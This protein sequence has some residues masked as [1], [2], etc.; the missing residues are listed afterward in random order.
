[1]TPVL[2]SEFTADQTTVC[3]G[4]TVNFINESISYNTSEWSFEGGTP[5]T[6][7]EE[8]PS[9]VYST[10]GVYD[11]ELT[12]TDISGASD[13]ELKLDYITVVDLPA[14]AGVPDG[15][16]ETCA[17]LYYTYSVD[18][19]LYAQEYEWELSP[20]GAGTLDAN[21]NE[22]IIEFA[23]DW[24][25]DFT[26]KVRAT[27]VCGNGE[28]SDNFEGTVSESPEDFNLMGGGTYCLDGEGVEITL[29]GSQSGIGYELYLGEEPTGII[30]D[31]TG[32]EISFGLV[33]DEGYYIAIGSNENCSVTMS[34]QVQVEIVYPP[35][36]P[37]TPTGPTLVCNDTVSNYES[38][39]TV[40]AE[41]YQ[42]ILEPENAGAINAD[43]LE[44]VV[45][46]NT[47]FI[48]SAFIS[49]YGINECGDGDPSAEIEVSVG[50]ANPEIEGENLVCD[51]HSEDYEVA[52]N[53]GSSYN[54]TVTGGT[55]STGQGTYTITVLWGEA[56]VGLISVEEQSGDGCSGTSD[57]FE[58]T[59]DDCTGIDEASD[60]N[61]LMLFPNPTSNELNVSFNTS[62]DHITIVVYNQL[63]Q[64]M[65]A[66]E[67]NTSNETKSLKLNV[68][69]FTK[70]M[71][72]IEIKSKGELLYHKQFIKR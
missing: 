50:G 5:S 12:V 13:S 21:D 37:L 59:I 32:S 33:T 11:V 25:G 42:W 48:G 14:Q 26:L 57:E 7:T 61:A 47:D 46:W 20:T 28:W 1:M 29:D 27:N 31:G 19:I 67:I 16:N 51:N 45:E 68:A 8:N 39:G 9:V 71:Y 53:D 65:I 22:A 49:L 41:S 6:S 70:G 4:S 38:D 18:E 10:P 40:D 2:A 63:G 17:G 54:W 30:V 56:G 35:S 3:T 34:N 58:V 69:N 24:A 72:S 43:G 60:E 66:Q 23:S 62:D 44:S 36:E 55:I 64:K 52:D 15:E